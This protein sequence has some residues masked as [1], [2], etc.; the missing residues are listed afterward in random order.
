MRY[1]RKENVLL[2]FPSL[3]S[4]NFVMAIR[5]DSLLLRFI[6]SVHEFPQLD[7]SGSYKLVSILSIC[8]FLLPEPSFFLLHHQI[9]AFHV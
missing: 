6:Y 4:G 9:A 5:C 1:F 7:L 8:S 2:S 3:V